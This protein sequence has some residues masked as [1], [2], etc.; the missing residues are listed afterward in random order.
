MQMPGLLAMGLNAMD[1]GSALELRHGASQHRRH[2]EHVADAVACE[3]VG[4]HAG[5]GGLLAGVGRDRE[6]AVCRARC[7]VHA[8]PLRAGSASAY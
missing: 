7:C 4:K 5:A 8:V 6:L 1:R 3:H 2:H